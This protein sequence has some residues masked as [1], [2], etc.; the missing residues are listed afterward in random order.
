MSLV[1][2]LRTRLTPQIL[3]PDRGSGRGWPEQGDPAAAVFGTSRATFR[4][5]W[6]RG[7]FEMPATARRPGP[8]GARGV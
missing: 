7:L 4:M 6:R 2:A 1:A 5:I 8:S 3:G